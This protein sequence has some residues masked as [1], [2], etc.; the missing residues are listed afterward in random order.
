MFLKTRFL[1]YYLK[2]SAQSKLSSSRSGYGGLT[3]R[4]VYGVILMGK[5]AFSC[6]GL[7]WVLR[8]VSGFGVGRDY[9]GGLERLIG[10][11]WRSVVLMMEGGDRRWRWVEIGGVDDGGG[12]SV[13]DG[14]VERDERRK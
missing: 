10:V 4:T 14:V 11:V 5:G 6:G 7:F 9:R 13:D 12:G 3:D 2:T 8:I 1:L